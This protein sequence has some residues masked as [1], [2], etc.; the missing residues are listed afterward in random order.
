MSM[1]KLQTNH[2]PHRGEVVFEM[3][4]EQVILVPTFSNLVTIEQQTQLGLIEMASLMQKN[5]LRLNTVISVLENSCEPPLER[6]HIENFV[7]RA[8][9]LKAYEAVTY[10][11]ASAIS[12]GKKGDEKSRKPGKHKTKI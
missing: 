8:G 1:Q 6:K 5:Q 3:D 7:E 9:L 12:A 4:G 11:L 2:N 10:F